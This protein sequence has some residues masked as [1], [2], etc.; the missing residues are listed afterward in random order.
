MHRTISQV[1]DDVQRARWAAEERIARRLIGTPNLTR[2]VHQHRQRVEYRVVPPGAQHVDDMGPVLGAVEL[3][4]DE[5]SAR[6]L[7]TEPNGSVR[8]R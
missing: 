8:T 6:V 7:V 3:V 2:V 4:I 5:S 1:I